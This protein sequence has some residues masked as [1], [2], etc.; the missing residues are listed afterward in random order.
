M[1]DKPKFLFALREDLKD[2]KRFLPT[3]ATEGSAGWDVSCAFEDHK[4]RIVNQG[5]YLMIPL[6]IRFIAPA[7]WWLEMKP[8]SSTFVKKHMHALYGTLDC[9][10]RGWV[11]FCAKYDDPNTLELKFGE[12]IGQLIPVKLREM[13][14]EQIDNKNFDKYVEEENNARGAGGFG[15]TDRGVQK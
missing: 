9:D 7:G 12:R 2:D 15:S 10:Y 1:S 8:R 14:V 3:R 5:E 6:G 13:V 4:N 11:H